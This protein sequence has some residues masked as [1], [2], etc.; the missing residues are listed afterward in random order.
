MATKKSD[1]GIIGL[2]VMGQ[3]L[4]LNI[5]DKGYTVSVYNRTES[6]T[7]DFVESR[8]SGKRII[9]TYKIDEFVKSI[10]RPRKIVIMVKAGTPVDEMIS[11]LLPLLRPGDIVIDAG[12]S[13]YRDT[14]RRI[15]EMEE[16]GILYLGMGVSGGEYGALHGPSI[17]PGGNYKAYKEVE[18]ILVKISAKTDDGPCCTYVGKGSAGHFVKM[19]HNGVEYAIMEILAEAYDIMRNGIKMS[20][21]DVQKVFYRWNEGV[22]SSYLVEITYKILGK[23]DPYTGKYLIDVILDKA[24]QKGT[25]KW[26]SQAALD[27]GIPVPSITSAVEIR[28][29]SS[30]KKERVYLSQKIKIPAKRLLVN[31]EKFIQYF[32]D[33]VYVSI[34]ACYAQG[35]HLLRS[36]SDEFS[37]GLN[38]KEIARIWKGGCIIRSKVLDIITKVYKEEPTLQNPLFSNILIELINSKIKSV[39]KAYSFVKQL[40]IPIPTLDSTLNYLLCFARENLPTNIIQAQR[41]YFG[42]HT[43]QRKDKEGTFHTEWENMY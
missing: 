9:P 20:I 29:L 26:T 18:E 5:E 33:Y 14:E 22:L 25:G 17:M 16:R 40:N 32:S 31:K 24:E 3:N 27:L 34:L 37:Y 38:L 30:F 43:Y 42:A 8:C 35:F 2:A 1:I 21:E 4:A 13:H 23:V 41:D 6:K 36:A 12:N 7:K 19:V 10:K 28:E 15:K 39:L 11:H